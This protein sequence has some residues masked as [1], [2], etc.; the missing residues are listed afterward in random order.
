MPEYELDVIKSRQVRTIWTIAVGPVAQ[1]LGF[2]PGRPDQRTPVGWWRDSSRGRCFFSF[3]IDQ[4]FGF[5]RRM[6][7]RFVVNFSASESKRD[8]S[9][10]ARMWGLLDP[11]AQVEAVRMNNRVVESL[12]NPAEEIVSALPLDLRPYYLANFKVIDEPPPANSDVWFRYATIDHAT[13][14]GQFVA[15]HLPEVVGEVERRLSRQ[16]EGTQSMAGHLVKRETGP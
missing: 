2:R 8:V 15:S 10:W 14:W 11:T 1:H 5:D 12:P 4:R 9:L 16:A 6:G 7:G 3:Q 13:N